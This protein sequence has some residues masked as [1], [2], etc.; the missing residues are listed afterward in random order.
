MNEKIEEIC[1]NLEDLAEEMYNPINWIL[2]PFIWALLLIFY[3]LKILIN[4]TPIGFISFYF[5]VKKYKEYNLNPRRKMI[6]WHFMPMFFEN[7]WIKRRLKKD[8][9]EA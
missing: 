7:F 4:D 8:E 2:T 6:G 3:L 1:E 9:N 5:V